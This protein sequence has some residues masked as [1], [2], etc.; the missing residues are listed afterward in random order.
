MKKKMA[1][2]LAG[3]L[4]ISVAGCGSTGNG[5]D[6]VTP[7]TE[8][9]TSVEASQTEDSQTDAGTEGEGSNEIEAESDDTDQ[10]E[11][12]YLQTVFTEHDMKVGTCLTTQMLR[13][14]KIKQIILDQF[15]SVTMENSMKPDYLFNKNES[16][17]TGDLVVEFDKDALT[18][19]EFAK[20]NGLSMRGHTLVWYSQ[21]PSWIFYED[22]DTKKDLVGRDVMLARMESY[23]KQVF[24]KLTELGYADMFY[25]YD[26]VNEAWM[27]DGSMRE[28]NWS[29]TIG[30]DYLWQAFYF[31]D[32]YAPEHIDLYYNDYNEQFKT[33]TLLKFVDTLKDENG[34]YLIDGVGFQAHLYTKDDLNTYFDT[35][36]AISAT[37]LKIQ[38]TELDVCLG[39]WQNTLEPTEE[40]LKIQGKFYYDLVNGLFER[41]DAG[42]LQMDALT[43]WGFADGL[44]WRKE[45]SPLLYDK[46]YQPKYSFYGAMQMKEQAG[47]DQ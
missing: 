1:L 12:L 18:M 45:A 27:E 33:D 30:D 35:V 38:L 14:D 2:L 43:F 20:E 23:I 17:A 36:D 7:E 24:E 9:I 46:T 28:N 21:T 31:A 26:V 10:S 8:A 39:A 16:I 3:L 19:M 15:N 32:K 13:N 41:K 47:F 11:G 42:T 29:A 5:G 37:G 34:D 25:A 44:S 4:A 6:A 40:N 22:F